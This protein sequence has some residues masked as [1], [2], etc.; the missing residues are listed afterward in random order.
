MREILKAIIR[1]WPWPLTIN[2]RYDRQTKAIIKKVC[3]PDSVCIDI[4]CYRGD[5]LKSMM[6]FAPDA[7]HKAFEPIPD[8]YQFLKNKFGD[9]AGIYPFALGDEN[10]ETSFHHVT[11]NPTYS[12]LKQ[13]QYKGEENIVEIKVQVKRLDD[14]VL[15]HIPIHLI[16]I[17]VEGGEFDVMKGGRATLYKWKP[18]LIFEHGIGG[19]DSYGIRPEEVYDFLVNDLGY[20][21]CLMRDYLK[22]EN[23]KGFTKQ[24]FEEQFWKGKNCYFLGVGS[25]SSEL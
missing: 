16:K 25:N 8:Q 23:L 12:G 17:D 14:V 18:Y 4:G 20:K 11:S 1:I 24:E 2:E 19:S 6:E 7:I 22:D 3:K 15:P 10:H 5:I 21:I 9:K 13:R